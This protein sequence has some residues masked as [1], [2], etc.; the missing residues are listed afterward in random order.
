MLLLYMTCM[1]RNQEEA[2]ERNGRT[3]LL[4]EGRIVIS[5]MK[6]FE[7]TTEHIGFRM[8]IGNQPSPSAQPQ[9]QSRQRRHMPNGTLNRYLRLAQQERS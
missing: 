6:A 2:V 9:Q 1:P 8:S 3:K 4:D 7:S 5:R